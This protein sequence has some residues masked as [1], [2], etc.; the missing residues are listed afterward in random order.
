M[1]WSVEELARV[2]TYFRALDRRFFKPQDPGDL[3]NLA[4]K[5][6]LDYPTFGLWMFKDFTKLPVLH[7]AK[8]RVSGTWQEALEIL[9]NEGLMLMAQ[10]DNNLLILQG[11]PSERAI[12]AWLY[13][14]R[15]G[16]VILK[17]QFKDAWSQRDPDN[18]QTR[19]R[20]KHVG[21]CETPR[22]AAEHVAVGDP[23]PGCTG[24]LRQDAAAAARG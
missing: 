10:I 14:T 21:P 13:P 20:A 15:V 2:E 23:S 6:L 12:V 18:P 24:A 7:D 17:L 22:R 9:T 4:S 16:A 5:T 11:P 3:F 19:A 1:G 8:M